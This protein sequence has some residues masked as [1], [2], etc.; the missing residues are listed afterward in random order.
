[1]VRINMLKHLLEVDLVDPLAA[2][3]AEAVVLVAL[4]E[5]RDRVFRW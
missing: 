3:R 1:M 5:R 4:L 2:N